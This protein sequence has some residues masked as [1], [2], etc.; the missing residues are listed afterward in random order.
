MFSIIIPTYNRAHLISKGID[1]ILA[2]TFENWEL[3]I[4]D[5]GSTDNTKELIASYQEKDA[6]IRY[7]YQENSERSAARNNGID[8]AKGNYICF[9]DSD[10]YYLP[11]HLFNLNN[12]ISDQVTIYYVG[13]VLER[14]KMLLKRDE[15]P[16]NGLKKFNQLCLATIHSQQVCIPSNIAKAYNFNPLIRI[17]EDLELW[18]RINEHHTFKYIENSF[19]VVV[20]DHTDRTID[21]K[22]NVGIEQLA[23]Y[24]YI[25]S[26]NHP[27]NLISM[28]VKK[29]LL[30]STYF[31]IFKF[32]LFK[33]S[34]I[35]CLYYL[36]KSI[37]K[38]PIHEQTKY[39]IHLLVKLFLGFSFKKIKFF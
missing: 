36:M 30:S 22:N 39:K 35:N 4:V 5:D 7:I 26:K 24:R 13:L 8:K 27:G 28:D 16:V 1:S 31:T 18:I 37:Y 2:Q 29:T 32:W 10:D 33:R 15:L 23:T 3:I 25:F 12:C 34:R 6:R 17:A 19:S 11:N 38:R 20:V 14:E 21:L 9:L